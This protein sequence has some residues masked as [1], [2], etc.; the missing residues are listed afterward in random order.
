MFDYI[1]AYYNGMLINEHKKE[2][3]RTF[4]RKLQIEGKAQKRIELLPE[5]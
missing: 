2:W 1:Q 3:Q 5:D 4:C